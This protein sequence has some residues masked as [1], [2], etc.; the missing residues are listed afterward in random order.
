MTWHLRGG[1]ELTGIVR[2]MRFS[3]MQT[4]DIRLTGTTLRAAG[5]PEHIVLHQG[6]QD[7][8]DTRLR[9]SYWLRERLHVGAALRVETSAVDAADVSPAAVD[10]LK[11][12]PSVMAEFKLGS[13]LAL[14]AGYGVTFMGA[15]DASPSRFD[16][17]AAAACAGSAPGQPPAGDL[18]NAGCVARA[19]GL[20]RPTAEGTYHR[21]VQDF[22]LSVTALF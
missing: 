17:Q 10:G 5:L 13:H 11:I 3:T 16:P 2:W 7:V 19:Q 8:W 9:L 4:M 12:E 15:V 14:G 22:G 20:A 1:L 18:G 21:F 6:F